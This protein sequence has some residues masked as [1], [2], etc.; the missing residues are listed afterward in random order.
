MRCV[1]FDLD[2]TLLN[3]IDGLEQA[4]NEVMRSHGYPLHSTKA[5]RYMVGEGMEVLA[6]RALPEE[7]RTAEQVARLV[8][9]VKAAYERCWEAGTRPYPGILELFGELERRGVAFS[10]LSNKP[11]EFTQVMVRRFFPTTGFVAVRGALPGIPKKPEPDVAVA[12]ARQM[13][14]APET[15]VFV[16]DTWVDIQTGVRAGMRA[17]GVRWGFRDEPELMQAGANV[18]I[19]NPLELL[20]YLGD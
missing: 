7:L 13:G 15:G 11:D 4:T 20:E 6:E 12:M 10:V 14:H 1:L 19:S 3:T 16:G 17:V 8:V 9:E 5:L 18:V 2:G